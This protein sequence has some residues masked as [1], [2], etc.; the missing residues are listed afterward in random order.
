MSV[1]YSR[2]GK[3]GTP[4]YS[5][6]RAARERCNNPNHK[7]YKTYGGRGITM[8]ARWS[9]FAN[10]LADVGF[11]SG[12]KVEIDRIDNDKGYWCGKSECPECGPLGRKP[13]CEWN[14]RSEQA[15]RKTNIERI[16]FD[17][18][19]KSLSEWAEEI[20]ISYQGLR[21]R[22]KHWGIEKALTLSKGVPGRVYSNY[23]MI[24]F[25]GRTMS[26]TA[27]ARELGIHETSLRE[28]IQK[29][30]LEKALTTPKS[31]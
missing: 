27:W 6:W 25:N 9:D 22:I 12:L 16:T 19:T 14:T 7:D 3:S 29:W 26:Q 18:V 30:G 28:R 8:C 21:H 17:G 31:R 1:R 2:H 20:G 15:K 10:F 5:S 4:E 23:V 13:N 11:R 24:T